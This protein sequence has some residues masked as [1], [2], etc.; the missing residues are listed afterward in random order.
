MIKTIFEYSSEEKNCSHPHTAIQMLC[1]HAAAPMKILS[2]NKDYET[3][4]HCLPHASMP[5]RKTK[6]FE[7]YD[8]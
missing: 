8:E 5:M 3:Y 7:S 1:F 6:S 4:N 2:E